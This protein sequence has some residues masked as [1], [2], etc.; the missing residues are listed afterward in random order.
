M[1]LCEARP[2]VGDILSGE[3]RESEALKVYSVSLCV[4]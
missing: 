3:N 2:N 1:T 4:F